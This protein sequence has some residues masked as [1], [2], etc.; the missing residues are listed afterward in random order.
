MEEASLDSPHGEKGMAVATCPSIRPGAAA[1]SKLA[2]VDAQT[3]LLE[4][5]V[6]EHGNPAIPGN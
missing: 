6:R 1:R 4:S 2:E 5:H 3:P